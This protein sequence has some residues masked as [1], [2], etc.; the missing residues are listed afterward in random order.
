MK[1]SKKN[2]KSLILNRNKRRKVSFKK[3]RRKSVR[4]SSIKRKYT[5][6]TKKNINGGLKSK[7]FRRFGDNYFNFTW[8]IL[9]LLKGNENDTP[10]SKDVE[11]N[12]RLFRLTSDPFVHSTY[13]NSKNDKSSSFV[14]SMNKITIVFFQGIGNSLSHA[15]N[16]S[17]FLLKS[18]VSLGFNCTIFV[19]DQ[20][21]ALSM[22]LLIACAAEVIEIAVSLG[23]PVTIIGFSLGTGVGTYGLLRWYESYEDT[24]LPLYPKLV[25]LSPFTSLSD[26]K[27]KRKTW[28]NDLMLMKY[29]FDT[30]LGHDFD[31]LQAIPKLP[32]KIYISGSKD[33]ATINYEQFLKLTNVKNLLGNKPIDVHLEGDHSVSVNLLKDPKYVK[34]FFT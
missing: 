34:Q 3:I 1:S 31:I 5:K 20:M 12:A 25:L 21:K 13:I 32:F 15:L 29:S 19:M 22:D 18:L 28:E 9:T 30:L 23:H 7:N 33:D 11:A 14:E 10:L 17:E 6:N 4:R 16:T 2:H 24:K 26:V 27:E 8:N